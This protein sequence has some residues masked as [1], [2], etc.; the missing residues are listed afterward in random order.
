[1]YLCVY[2]HG[3]VCKGLHGTSVQGFTWNSVLMEVRGT[4]WSRFSLPFSEF[5]GCQ[6]TNIHRYLAQ[7]SHLCR[8]VFIDQRAYC[9]F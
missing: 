2:Y 6:A 8:N 7:P 4:L 1:M 9:Y 3:R 5:L